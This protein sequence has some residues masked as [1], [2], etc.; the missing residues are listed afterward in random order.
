MH[1]L[2]LIGAVFL[3]R[4]VAMNLK[5]VLKEIVM[6]SDILKIDE[7]FSLPSGYEFP[8]ENITIGKSFEVDGM[9][10]NWGYVAYYKGK[11]FASGRNLDRLRNAMI[12]NYA[13]VKNE[14]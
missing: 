13:R 14:Q 11:L 7:L 5:M 9:V 10:E 2:T 4:F 8:D 12:L 3:I 1:I 6:K